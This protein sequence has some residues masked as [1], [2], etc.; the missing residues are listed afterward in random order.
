MYSYKFTV[1]DSYRT[2]SGFMVY[3]LGF[4]FRV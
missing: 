2:P 3:N 1:Y 4:E